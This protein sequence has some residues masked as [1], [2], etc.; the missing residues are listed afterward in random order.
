MTNAVITRD[1]EQVAA[2]ER[3]NLPTYT[4]AV[5]IF[6]NSEKIV[7]LAE[8][9][10]VD[11]ESVDITYE[12]GVLEL[13]GSAHRDTF[14]DFTVVRSEAPLGNYKRTFKLVEDIDVENIEASIKCGVLKLVLPIHEKAK[15]RKISVR[16]E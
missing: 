9:P 14:E 11:E 5:E 13:R 15:P 2:N 6:Q 7:L 4:P 16:S 3:L 8:M 1:N 10:G 12:R